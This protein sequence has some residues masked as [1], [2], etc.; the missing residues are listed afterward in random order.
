[1]ALRR[2][3]QSLRPWLE[4]ELGTSLDACAGAPVPVIGLESR[5]ASDLPLY[6]V[7]IEESAV[8]T[9]RPDWVEPLRRVLAR[10][11]VEETF[12][13]LGVFDITRVTLA[14]GYTAWG[15]FWCFAAD[16][17]SLRPV[18]DEHVRE[19]EPEE[20]RAVA[21]PE[22]FWRCFFDESLL[23]GFGVFEGERLVSLA[24]VKR[25]SDQLLE[26]GVESASDCKGRGLGRAVLSAGC[27]WILEQGKLPWA[28][29]SHWNVP[30]ARTLKS[31]GFANVWSGMI[32]WARPLQVPPQV[33]GSP[34]PG[35][36]MQNFYPD[37]AM[38][39]DIRP[40]L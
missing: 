22:V 28:T 40:R 10:L 36:P 8:M 27:R 14:D 13:F 34:R 33:V 18:D 12:S 23:K 24:T 16:A 20:T 39:K 37:R 35:T 3:R 1:M 30:S 15:P 5:A 9:V 21:D 25:E 31:L 7:K 38:N 29:T 17:A 26:L 6:A 11:S 4:A 32:A 2:L 19:L